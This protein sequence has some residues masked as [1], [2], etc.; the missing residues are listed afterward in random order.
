MARDAFEI[1]IVVARKPLKG[2]WASHAWLPVAALPSAPDTAPWTSLG[3]DGE[4]QLFYAGAAEIALHAPSTGHYRDNLSAAAPSLWVVMRPVGEEVELVAATVDPYEAEALAENIGDMVEAVAMPAEVH[5]RIAAFVEAF[6]VER[7]FFKRK[8]RRG[9][10]EI[11]E[12]LAPRRR[13][14]EEEG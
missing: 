11:A 2:P 12:K 1:G 6:H 13:G 3:Q 5:E 7:E 9:D 10:E 8:R 14:A 4:A